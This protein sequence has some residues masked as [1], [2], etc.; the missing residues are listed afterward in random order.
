MSANIGCV[1]GK[2]VAV[3]DPV[4]DYIATQTIKVSVTQA[5]QTLWTSCIDNIGTTSPSVFSA[6]YKYINLHDPVNLI[7]RTLVDNEQ[8]NRDNPVQII[9]LEFD[10]IFTIPYITMSGKMCVNDVVIDTGN[11]IFCSGNLCYKFSLPV[12]RMAN[13]Q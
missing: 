12:A 9:N 3:P 8:F 2:L 4:I 11:T 1:S 6:E 7:F 13:A 5:N 10:D